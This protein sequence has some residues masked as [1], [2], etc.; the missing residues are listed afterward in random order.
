M[1]SER[2]NRDDIEK[3]YNILNHEKETEIRVFNP[4]KSS[5]V[6]TKTEYINKVIELS[7]EGKDVYT[8]INERIESG[9]RDEDVKYLSTIFIDFD[10]HGDHISDEALQKDVYSLNNKLKDNG[11]KTSLAF[12]GRGYHI[13]IPFKRI[14]VN[15]SN[16]ETIKKKIEYFKN[17]L[18]DKFAVDSKTFNLS[19][20]TRV[21][22]TYNNSAEKLSYWMDYTGYDDN[23]EFIDFIEALYKQN[24]SAESSNVKEVNG[25]KT[26]ASIE[27]AR[28]CKFFDEI[29]LQEKMP[30]GSRHA[31]LI[32]N[33]SVYTNFSGNKDLRKN[34]LKVQGMDEQEFVGWDEKFKNDEFR[35]FNCGE[36]S[37]Y[38]KE[39]NLKD[40]C[41]LCPYNNFR[42]NEKTNRSVKRAIRASFEVKKI[43]YQHGIVTSGIHNTT[44]K[45]YVY[46][47]F[48]I[49]FL[50]GNFSSYC[51]TENES[52]LKEGDN[53]RYLIPL[54]SNKRLYSIFLKNPPEEHILEKIL[55]S[56]G[57]KNKRVDTF[58]KKLNDNNKTVFDYLIE[59]DAK[60]TNCI[61]YTIGHGIDEADMKSLSNEDLKDIVEHYVR[62]GMN[63]DDKVSLAFESDFFVPDMS[64]SDYKKYQYYN[65]HKFLFTGTK[66]GKSTISSRFGHNAIRTTVKNLLGFSTS[67]EINRGTLHENTNPYYL[68]EI[69]EDESKMMYGKLLSFMESGEVNIDVGKKSITCRG[70]SSLTFLGNPKDDLLASERIN[71]IKIVSQFDSTLKLI[72]NNYAALG[73]RIALV[74]FDPNTKR[75]SGDSKLTEDEVNDLEAKF[76]YLRF[77]TSK[78]FSLLLKNPSVLKFLDAP[79]EKNYQDALT[80]LAKHTDMQ[81]FKEF[82]VGN[83]SSH[84][85]M[86][87]M[88]LRLAALEYMNDL[89]ND[90]IDFKKLIDSAKKYLHIIQGI[91][92]N[93]FKEMIEGDITNSIMERYIKS[94]F[95]DEAAEIKC[96]LYAVYSYVR[97]NGSDKEIPFV[98]L[99]KYI[100]EDNSYKPENRGTP[101]INYRALKH[102]SKLAQSYSIEI[103]E[104]DGKR[105]ILVNNDKPLKIIF[106]D[107]AKDNLFATEG[108]SN[109]S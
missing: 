8:G 53:E 50:A 99:E 37:N 64:I 102:S 28:K 36:I 84:K 107:F 35:I 75:I 76:E 101:E 60:S 54:K 33:L 23:D 78:K 25:I 63:V 46:N 21:I 89:I 38:C 70:L 108:G 16:R 57:I 88:A 7:D 39:H 93:S 5:F 59:Q 10:A 83:V 67:D 79:F 3:Y 55:I 56:Q 103:S 65:N 62:M 9:K 61:F 22:G 74:V 40:V 6:K 81:S 91:N 2:N 94:L 47:L 14:K 41:S 71:E 86:N 48:E 29:C 30:E 85:H 87:G 104:I 109:E 19:R 97:R 4:A 45:E 17:F 24:K 42:Y 52:D 66:A 18:I 82:L 51:F 95:D 106:G 15:E 20:V 98:G 92:I 34:F 1:V 77:I 72:T 43:F 49:K 31:T 90:D 100:L 26:S 32:K 68:D 73:S 80:E 13:L 58:I 105:F 11:I 69:Q 96:F 12:S 27:G 44:R